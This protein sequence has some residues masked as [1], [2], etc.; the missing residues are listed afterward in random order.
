MTTIT[1]LKVALAALDCAREQTNS[2]E[3]EYAYGVAAKDLRSVIAEME[4]G[5]PVAWITQCGNLVRENEKK[6]A[7]LYGWKPLYTHPQPKE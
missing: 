6:N 3:L 2:A 4:A 5:E 1:K 7:E